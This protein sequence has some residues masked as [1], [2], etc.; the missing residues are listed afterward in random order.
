[1]VPTYACAPTHTHTHT[2][3]QTHTHAHTHTSFHK[4][5]IL[6]GFVWTSDIVINFEVKVVLMKS[7]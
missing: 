5:S 1:L 6:H 4:V 3:T 2:H 7:F